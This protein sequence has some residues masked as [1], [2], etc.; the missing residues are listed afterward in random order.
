MSGRLLSVQKLTSPTPLKV[1]VVVVRIAKTVG[2]T[3]R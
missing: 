1:N 2:K 3:S